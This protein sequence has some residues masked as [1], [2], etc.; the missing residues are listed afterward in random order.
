MVIAELTHL[1]PIFG[2]APPKDAGAFKEIVANSRGLVILPAFTGAC[3]SA[4]RSLEYIIILFAFLDVYT[5]NHYMYRNIINCRPVATIT[6]IFI[7]LH[8]MSTVSYFIHGLPYISRLYD[9][10]FQTP[11]AVSSVKH[12]GRHSG[13]ASLYARVSNAHQASVIRF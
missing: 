12:S 9:W 4:C 7:V 11:I 5:A 10:R 1:F 6:M 13:S 8:I 3:N 2:A